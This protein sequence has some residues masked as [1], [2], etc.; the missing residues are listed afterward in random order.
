MRGPGWTKKNLPAGRTV[1]YFAPHP[2]ARTAP[3][4]N[5]TDTP[6][7]H[8]NHPRGVRRLWPYFKPARLYFGGGL[9]AGGV[10]AAASGVG[11]PL[12]LYVVA[13]VVFGKQDDLST[14]SQKVQEWARWLFGEHYADKLLL[15]ACLALPLIFFIRGV[16]SFLNRYWTNKAGFLMLEA[17]RADVFQRLQQLPLAFYHRHKSGDLTSRLMTDTEQ[18]RNV[19]VQISGDIIKQPLTLL[20]AVGTLIVLA[21]LNKS[22]VFLLVGMASIPLLVLPLRAAARRIIKRSRALT[23]QTGELTAIVTESL[24]SPME[25]QAYN[26]QEIQRDRFVTQVRSILRL[27]MKTVKYQALMHPGIEFVGAC[28]FMVALY[29]GAS[30]GMSFEIFSAMAAAMYMSY[31]P[32][33]KLSNINAMLKIGTASLERLEH[34]LDAEDSVP[35]PRLPQPLPAGPAPITFEHVSFTYANRDVSDVPTPALRDVHLQIAPGEVVAL[36]GKSGAGK[37]T[38]AALLPRFYDPTK[39]RVLLGAVDLRAADKTELRGRIALVPQMP[40]LFNASVADNIRMGRPGA[41]DLE[42]R[43][44]AQKA[45]VADFIESLPQGYDTMVGE[46]GASLSGGQRQRIAIARAFLKD[47]PILILDEAM[48]ALDAESEAKVQKAL[49][50]LIQ[51][52]TTFMIT[53]RFNSLSLAT[54]VLFFDGGRISGD[55]PPV[56]LARS[57]AEYRM[58]TE[59]QGLSRR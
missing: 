1:R 55:G 49:E 18:L 59:L 20:G 46:R 13:P 36:V 28:G 23:A 57:H 15:V 27:A 11:L 33:K 26:L 12:V 38:F 5:A 25:V 16:S 24:Q 54:R 50:V 56:A 47:A 31:E 43:A 21:F 48:S 40:T 4:M 6:I 34:I 30:H 9:L 37:S 32:V 45:F 52:R 58:M 14:Q 17:L 53:H 19:V 22:A 51:G 44:A 2:G 3:S 8:S 35:Q 39:G 42:V 10:F 29:Y 41:A 7:T